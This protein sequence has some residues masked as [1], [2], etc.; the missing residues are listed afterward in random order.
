MNNQTSF[1]VC[2]NKHSGITDRCL[3]GTIY[4]VSLL[5]NY[6]EISLFGGYILGSIDL[7]LF[8]VNLYLHNSI[9][10]G[11]ESCEMFF[12]SLDRV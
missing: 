8:F 2:C 1:G 10:K 12:K 5:H 4:L 6:P 11:S 3:A 7:A 9:R